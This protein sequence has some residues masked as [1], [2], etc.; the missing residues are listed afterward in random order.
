M[1]LTCVLIIAVLF[2]TAI[3]ADDSKDKQVY[4]AVGLTDKMRRVRASDSCRKEGERCPSRPCCPRLR[5]GSGRIGGVCRY[6]Y[7]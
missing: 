5:C 6:P 2:L 1:K 7:N 3:T 4:R